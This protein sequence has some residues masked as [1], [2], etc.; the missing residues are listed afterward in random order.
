MVYGFNVTAPAEVTA[1]AR[2]A[3]TPLRLVNV[4]YR[5]VDD[6]RDEVNKLMPLKEVEEVIGQ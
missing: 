2:S 6:V 4:I 5:L 1:Q 3:N